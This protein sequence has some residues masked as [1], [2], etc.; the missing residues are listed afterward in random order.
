MPINNIVFCL[1]LLV[2]Y[3]WNAFVWRL[4]VVTSGTP[5][6]TGTLPP[7][8]GC[9]VD[10]GYPSFAGEFPM[11]TV[12][13]SPKVFLRVLNCSLFWENMLACKQTVD[14]IAR[15]QK[16]RSPKPLDYLDT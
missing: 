1:E 4:S 10:L 12:P 7:V 16:V 6:F 14:M 9:A 13:F 8:T 2:L 11:V 5:S 3:V 15:G